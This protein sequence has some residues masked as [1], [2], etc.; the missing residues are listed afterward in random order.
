M[1]VIYFLLALEKFQCL[2][3]LISVSFMVWFRSY[4]SGRSQNTQLR[5]TLYEAL[6]VSVGVPQGSIL[7]PLF[8]IS[9]APRARKARACAEPHS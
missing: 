1:Q 9:G 3:E 8:F 5:G 2:F 7:G 4:L 6:P